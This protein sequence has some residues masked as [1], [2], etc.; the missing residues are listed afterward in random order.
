MVDVGARGTAELVAPEASTSQPSTCAQVMYT[1]VSDS[2][3]MR[4]TFAV[5]AR[6]QYGSEVSRWFKD[7][8]GAAGRHHDSVAKS[9]A[10]ENAVAVLVGRVARQKWLVQDE[11]IQVHE[12]CVSSLCHLVFQCIAPL[13]GC[14][15]SIRQ[16]V[17][18]LAQPT[19]LPFCWHVRSKQH[20]GMV[21]QG[22]LLVAVWYCL[23]T[24]CM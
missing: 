19:W 7:I 1:C 11:C 5:A 8:R 17:E 22:R 14:R 4:M 12:G 13:P 6:C 20:G 15:I 9:K 10:R 24:W 23:L 16:V 21:I 18:G 2:L 3:G